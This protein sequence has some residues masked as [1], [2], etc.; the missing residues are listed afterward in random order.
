MKMKHNKKRNTAFIYEAIIRELAKAIHEGNVR[1]KSKIIKIIRQN[2]KGSTLLE[3][4]LD[5]YK[6]I[7]E[8]R[9]VDKYTA[10]KIVFQSRIQ[11]NTINHKK[12]FQQQSH[13]IEE[14]NKEIS[15]DVF[16]NFVPNY[17]D[18]ATIFQIFHPKTT[19]KNRVLLEA[20]IISKML[21]SEQ[22]ENTAMKSIDNLTYKTFV[23]KFNEKYTSSLIEEQKEL[24]SKF[25]ASFSDNGIDLKVYLNEE[26]PRLFKIVA[27]SK[28]LP[29][30]KSDKDMLAKTNQVISMLKETSDRKIDKDFVY[31]ILKIQNLAKEM[32]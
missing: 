10:E 14:I 5:L 32:K 7:L 19:T 31:D 24:L 21:V 12:L 22:D 9:G 2:F 25:I 30:I 20:Q 28:K 8:T 27:E 16:S 6:S 11:K 29:E 23:K 13:L 26:I 4:D 15:P 3:K 18:L 17:K 1:N